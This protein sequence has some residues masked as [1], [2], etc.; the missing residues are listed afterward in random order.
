M[1]HMEEIFGVRLHKVVQIMHFSSTLLKAHK[2][3]GRSIVLW[4]YGV[5]FRDSEK[6][7]KAND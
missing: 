2:N 6:A 1:I 4:P 3:N 7:M 5:L